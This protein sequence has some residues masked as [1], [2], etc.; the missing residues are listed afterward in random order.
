VNR[1]RAIRYALG[2]LLALV[3]I[4]AFGGGWY[5]MAGASGVPIAWLRGSPFASYL[6]PS[7]IL[8]FVVGGAFLVAAIAV[9]ARSPRASTLAAIAGGIAGLWIA[10]QIAIIGVVSWL[11][12]TVVAAAL[13]VILLAGRLRPSPP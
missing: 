10:A 2:G 12:P 11:Q 13:L 8:F 6:V 3:A 7:A 4:N 5:G 9:F 1:D